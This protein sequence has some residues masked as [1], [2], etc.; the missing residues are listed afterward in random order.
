VGIEVSYPTPIFSVVENIEQENGLLDILINN[1]GVFL[2]GNITQN[3]FPPL[4]FCFSL[5]YL[6][7]K[8]RL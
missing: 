3:N 7:F 5:L 6:R 4:S 2:E 1:A 8:K